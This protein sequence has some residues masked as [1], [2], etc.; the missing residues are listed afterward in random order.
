MPNE[1]GQINS[2]DQ[3]ALGADIVGLVPSNGLIS[4]GASY[5]GIGLTY[6]VSALL[7]RIL[8]VIY[9]PTTPTQVTLA[10][11]DPTNPRID[12]I[13]AD[14]TGS[15]GVITGTPA[16]SPSKPNID[17]TSQ[18]EVTFI[19]VP[20]G[21]TA[22]PVTIENVYDENVGTG[23]GEWNT[24]LVGAPP[25]VFNDATDPY[26]GTVHI[27][28]SAA[29]GPNRA[30]VFDDAPYTINGGQLSFW[31][32]AKSNMGII[33]GK[34]EVGFFVGG[35]LVGNS[36]T[37]GGTASPTFGFSGGVIGTW[38]LVTIPI[39]SFGGLPT[40][41]DQ[42]RM[43]T[44]GGSNTAEF[45]MDLIKIEEGV[46]TAPVP[47][48]GH[49]IEDEGSAL[50]Q[51]PK[52][53]FVGAG[54]TVT[55]DPLNDE[56]VVT[57]PGGGGGGSGKFYHKTYAYDYVGASG[58]WNGVSVAAV[59]ATEYDDRWRVASF[60]GTG[61]ADGFY[62]NVKVPNSY[63]AGANIKLSLDFST[64]VGTGG[65]NAEITAGLTQPTAGN[66]MG[67]ETETEYISQVI[68]LPAGDG[69]VLAEFTFDGTNISPGDQ[70]AILV[71]RDPGA[72]AD[73]LNETIYNSTFLLEEQ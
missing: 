33:S 41:I 31:M 64:L 68:A 54:V 63:T 56:T 13:Y 55:D 71:Y 2:N 62:V 22:P 73:V 39:V 34:I 47:V 65:A 51:R 29:F 45:D 43:F 42:L 60:A 50:T 37:I 26:S 9:G 70:L 19:N 10:A 14:N 28:T 57:I 3:V 24:S 58:T 18:V 17:N 44:G 30:M 32:K 25:V 20:A 6:D 46:P 1:L 35:S 61:G 27:A 5:S 48:P 11:A 23:G 16:A 66:A 4:G 52:M 36:V 12:V 8:G 72:A 49:E 7:Y 21:A 38:Q 59:G 15:V 40:T 67:S 53:N 69:T